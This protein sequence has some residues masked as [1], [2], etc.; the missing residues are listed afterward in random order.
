[1]DLK[2]SQKKRRKKEEKKGV[3]RNK[4]REGIGH[5]WANEGAND[6]D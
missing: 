2:P 6:D 1:L 5:G 4:T 3:D